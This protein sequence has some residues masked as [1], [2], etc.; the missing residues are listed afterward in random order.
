MECCKLEVGKTNWIYQ[1]M[2]SNYSSSLYVAKFFFPIGPLSSCSLSEMGR[3][4]FAE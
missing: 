1:V 4:A 2:Y 3:N